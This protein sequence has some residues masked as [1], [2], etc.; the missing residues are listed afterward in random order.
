MKASQTT[1]AVYWSSK[2]PEKSEEEISM[3]QY[4]NPYTSLFTHF[5][6][7]NVNFP[8]EFKQGRGG[9]GF[10]TYTLDISDSEWLCKHCPIKAF[11]YEC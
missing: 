6:S 4:G 10:Q 7:D 3:H 2:M 8:W 9:G 11:V 5:H 1:L